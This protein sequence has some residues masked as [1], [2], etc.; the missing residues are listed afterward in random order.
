[1][2]AVEDG[3]AKV[4]DLTIHYRMAGGG[5]P[6]VLIHGLGA[7]TGWWRENISSLASF[8]RL[9][10]VDLPGHGLSDKRRIRYSLDWGSQF[11]CAFMAAVGLDKATLVGHSMG[12]TLAL[13]LAL[14]FPQR[15]KQLVLV[16]S[17]GLGGEVMWLLRLLTV[18]L[19]GEMLSAPT[20]MSMKVLMS[21]LFC[22]PS[23]APSGFLEEMCHERRAAGVKR[24]VLAML[25]VGADLWGQR[26]DVI[27]LERLTQ[28]RVPTLIVWG[29]D[30]RIVP[31]VHAH[32]AHQLIP[33]SK[34]HVIP[35]CGHCPQLEKPGE[36]NRIILDFLASASAH[37]AR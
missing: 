2:P 5:P 7:S 20:R 30:D 18:P 21:R 11:L 15:V 36:F 4:G 25:R 17:A 37:P 31:A 35:G 6:V 28:V 29:A 34:L 22:R 32:T 13:N 24:A 27:L 14:H 12:G 26:P 23:Q 10:L 9:F 1:M 19:L 3:Y 33:D 8:Y 16:D